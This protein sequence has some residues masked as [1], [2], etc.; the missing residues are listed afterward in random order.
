MKNY[1]QVLKLLHGNRQLAHKLSLKMGNTDTTPEFPQVSPKFKDLIESTKDA[2]AYAFIDDA[3][4]KEIINKM[5][6]M[7][8]TFD[9]CFATARFAQYHLIPKN[10]YISLLKKALDK[11]DNFIEVA[12]VYGS[13]RLADK[14]CPFVKE[15]WDKMVKLGSV[16]D[17][18]S[19][20][21]LHLDSMDD[22]LV[23]IFITQI[24]SMLLTADIG[25]VTN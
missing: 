8:D 13:L 4:I 3:P 14:D 24:A 23:D 1:E 9:E 10:K 2:L 5:V 19:D 17:W 15:A 18:I 16:D 21:F 12:V 6:K 7:A 25:Q 20:L 22:E 11:S